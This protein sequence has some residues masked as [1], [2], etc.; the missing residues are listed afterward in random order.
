MQLNGVASHFWGRKRD[1]GGLFN[2]KYTSKVYFIIEKLL[3][4]ILDSW[5]LFNKKNLLT[6]RRK[7]INNII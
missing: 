4:K 1:K 2:G 7:T 6:K 3:K 5:F